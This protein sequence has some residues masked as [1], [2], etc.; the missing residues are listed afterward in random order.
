MNI[1]NIIRRIRQLPPLIFAFVSRWRADSL[2]PPLQ[3][4]LELDQVTSTGLRLR[5]AI[6]VRSAEYWLQLGASDLALR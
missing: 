6:P 2:P 1:K 4:D 5:E 3:L